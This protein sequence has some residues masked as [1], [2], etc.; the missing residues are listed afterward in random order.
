MNLNAFGMSLAQSEYVRIIEKKHTHFSSEKS[1]VERFNEITGLY[2]KEDTSFGIINDAYWAGYTY[3]ELF[4]H[5][6][7]SFSYIFLKLPVEKMFDMY[8][9][10]HE[11][12]ISQVF[13]YFMEIENKESIIK[14]LCERHYVSLASLARKTGISINTLKKYATSDENL[15]NASYQHIFKISSELDEPFS[16]FA[17]TI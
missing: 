5:I 14:L 12:D 1:I 13:D 10:Y 9:V 7:K 8:D 16:L 4:L 6:K 2:V 3:F 15:Y 11:M 17:R